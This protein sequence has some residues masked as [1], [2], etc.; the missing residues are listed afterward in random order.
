M[1]IRLSCR[2]EE[3]TV[4]VVDDG[5]GFSQN[6]DTVTKPFYHG[7]SRDNLQHF[8]MGMYISRVYC[9]R[10]GGRLITENTREGGAAVKA[11]FSGRT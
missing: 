7:D 4:E 11:I 10:H 8:G 5:E 9:E 3:L 6:T 2:G 1:D